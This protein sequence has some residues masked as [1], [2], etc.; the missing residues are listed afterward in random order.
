MVKE[1]LFHLGDCKTGTT[2]IQ[3]VL[4]GGTIESDLSICFPTRFNHIPLAR[5]LSVPSEKHL[6]GRLF[7]RLRQAFKNS[8]ADIGVVSAEHFEFVQ[9]DEIRRA[10]DTHLGGYADQIR[11][12]AYV[13]PHAERLV[14]TFSE[15]TKKGVFQNSLEKMHERLLEDGIL[16]Y[17]PRF[18]RMREL[19]GDQ[20][21]LRPFI[22][23][24]LR[25]GDVV[26]DFFD[27]LFRGEKFNLTG[28]TQVNESLSVQDI[29]LMR[30]L[31]RRVDAYTEPGVDRTKEK[32]SLGWYFAE[33]LAEMPLEEAMKPRLHVSLAEK[34]VETY[35]EDAAELDAEFFDGTP[36]SD[37]LVS[38]PLKAIPEEQSYDVETYFSNSE[39]RQIEAWTKLTTRLIDSAPEFFSWLV[40]PE[41]QRP[42]KPPVL[43]FKVPKPKP[44]KKPEV[45]AE[46]TDVDAAEP[47][48]EAAKADLEA[49]KTEAEVETPETALEMSDVEGAEV[50]LETDEAA[51]DVKQSGTEGA[52]ADAETEEPA[53][54]VETPD[55]VAVEDTGDN[56]T[57][58]TSEEAVVASTDEQTE[59]TEDRKTA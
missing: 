43:D 36:I 38:A 5:T 27:L 33:I 9:P 17:A 49:D 35:A 53:A 59:D 54:G 21:I 1:I 55:M 7:K 50:A 42:A 48:L 13:R 18:K 15:R 16:F 14:S 58:H 10:I 32:H 57:N 46:K 12:V 3:S 11:L 28:E 39:L 45:A 2:A 44:P 26:S 19:F 4:A 41:E 51:G 29:A 24:D 52:Q 20:F 25:D 8:D 31:H 47:D 56:K 6:E 30:H 40:R 34:I 37:A 23:D 22:R